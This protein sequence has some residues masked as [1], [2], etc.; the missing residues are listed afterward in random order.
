M[1]GVNSQTWLKSV[2]KPPESL[3]VRND[4]PQVPAEYQ[5][6]EEGRI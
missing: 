6:D 1:L 3:L 4:S 2:E 5:S